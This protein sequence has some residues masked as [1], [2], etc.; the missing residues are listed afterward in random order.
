MAKNFN[1]TPQREALAAISKDFH[2]RN[3]MA[4]TAGNLSAR[5]AD[6]QNSFWITASGLPKGCL[7][8][9]DMIQIELESGNVL[10]RFQDRAKPSA[11]TCIHQVIYRLYPQARACFHVHSVD[12]CLATDGAGHKMPLPP[13]E[14]MKGLDIWEQNPQIDLPIFDNHL[15]VAD[16]AYDIEH[17]FRQSPPQIP[18][19]MIRNH[20]TTVWGNS[21]QQTYNR[22][23]IIEFFMRY[24][25]RQTPPQ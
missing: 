19:L 9:D 2:S 13:L 10:Q 3:W 4:G 7:D 24:M 14:V 1:Q 17:R 5:T 20:G 11:E 16:I 21:L 6:D 8:A 15:N 12:A 23:E 22:V 18:A 25:A